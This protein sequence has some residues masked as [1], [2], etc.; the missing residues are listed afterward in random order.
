MTNTIQFL[1]ETQIDGIL[2]IVKRDFISPMVKTRLQEFEESDEYKKT[3]EEIKNSDEIQAEYA[4][5]VQT[6]EKQLK[7]FE[8]N[9]LVKELDTNLTIC[10]SEFDDYSECD[11]FSD[12]VANSIN[13][14][15]D[16]YEENLRI[17][18]LSIDRKTYNTLNIKISQWDVI[19][20]ISSDLETRLQ[21]TI[22]MDLDSIIKGIVPFI[23]IEKH[24]KTS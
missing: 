4:E 14:I 6:K 15:E 10:K 12:V 21:L 20:C 16:R 9:K 3:Y 1:T 19:S 18:E 13:D 24:I 8:L 22:P 2:S 7:I 23:S 5:A 11:S 17:I